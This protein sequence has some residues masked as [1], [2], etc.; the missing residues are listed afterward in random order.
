MSHPDTAQTARSVVSVEWLQ[1]HHDDDNVRVLDASMHLPATG[2]NAHEEFAQQRIPRAVFFDID[3]FSAASA[4]PHTLPEASQFAEAAGALGIAE[5][6]TIVVYDT[7]GL[8]SAARV[9]WMFRHYGATN[10]AVLDGGLPA[11]IRAGGSVEP[12]STTY[13]ACTFKVGTTAEQRAHEV[14]DAPAVLAASKGSAIILDARSAGRF[15]GTDKE[16]RAGLR[17]GHIPGSVSSPFVQVLDEQGMLKSEAQL[18]ALFAQWSVGQ[19]SQTI[20]TCGSGV[21]AAVLCLA[22]E[23]AGLPPAR[24]YD[25]S[26]SEW[27]SLNEMPVATSLE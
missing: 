14:V 17:S 16:A 12:L 7:V 9:W 1:A 23:R 20:T 4:L 22:L 25:G 21:T 10:V 2:R 19:D 18:Q 13:P 15:A 11:W 26:W 5:H 6:H 8:Y 3:A 27:G 24:L